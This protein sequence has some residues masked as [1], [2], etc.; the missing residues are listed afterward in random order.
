MGTSLVTAVING[1][2][3]TAQP[4]MTIMQAARAK[5]IK[6]PSLCYHPALE[7]SGACRICLVEVEKHP[8]LLPACTTPLSEG[9][10]I[11]THSPKAVAARRFVVEMILIRHPL[12]CFSCESNGRCDLQDL[13][14]ELG[15]EKSPFQEEGNV[16]TDYALDD[17]NPF[18]IRDMNKCVVCGRCVRACDWQ[19][20]YH[21]VDFQFR[22]IKT[23]V[24]PPVGMKLEDSD[25]VFCGQCVQAC[26]VGALIERKSI[27]QGR[28]WETEKVRT[29]CAYC[30]VGCQLDLHVKGEKIVR[31]TGTEEGMPNRGR[32]C[33]KGRFGYDF[34]YSE[35][36]LTKPLIRVR[37]GDMKSGD[38]LFREASWD[39]ALDLVASRFKEV[40][41]RHG[42]DAVGG[43]SCARSLN[44]DSYSMQKLFRMV[45]KT[46]NID[47]CARV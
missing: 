39:E 24:N 10:V 15:I 17:T 23:T 14:Y 1:K 16:C 25:C 32:L 2:T 21:A 11:F 27:G 38:D 30:G 18:Y 36:R 46:N 31:V 34:I 22:G 9:M 3:L 35:E 7:S 12:D 20:G 5:G 47:H 8:K 43:V 19:S 37:K 4:G 41:E 13:A 40:I 33:V 42:S 29:T 44:E 26:P 6:I 45:F 28:S